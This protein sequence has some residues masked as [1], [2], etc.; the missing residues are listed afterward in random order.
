MVENKW[1]V[2]G[3]VLCVGNC[4][5]ANLATALISSHGEPGALTVPYSGQSLELS[6]FRQVRL[7]SPQLSAS[8]TYD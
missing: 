7:L 4:G 8:T 2:S 3:G 1:V 6:I 5:G